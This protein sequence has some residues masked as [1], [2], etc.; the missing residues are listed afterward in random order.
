MDGSDVGTPKRRP[1]SQQGMHYTT[2][3]SP[4]RCSSA[5]ATKRPVTTSTKVI[6]GDLTMPLILNSSK[7]WLRPT[8]PFPEIYPHLET[9][10]L[11]P[12]GNAAKNT[13]A[14]VEALETTEKKPECID[15][16]YQGLNSH[17]GDALAAFLE[18]KQPHNNPH[19]VQV[20]IMNSNPKVGWKGV[21]PICKA[22]AFDPS[23]HTL[24]CEHVD[25]GDEG[26]LA[27]AQV[28]QSNTTLTYVNIAANNITPEGVQ[29]L[30]V[31]LT[32]NAT[33]QFLGL[34]Y[35]KIKDQ[36]GCAMAKVTS[37][38]PLAS[39]EMM[40]C[41]MSDQTIVA[42][43]LSLAANTTLTSLKMNK[44]E[45]SEQAI[46][47]LADLLHKNTTLLSVSISGPESALTK[48]RA[49]CRRNKRLKEEEGTK[50][51]EKEVIRLH[52]QSRK[53]S[54][55]RNTLKDYQQKSVDLEDSAAKT[56][57]KF[58]AQ[59]QDIHK[60]CR[61][62][63]ATINYSEQVVS[64]LLQKR[65][66]YKAS[67]EKER[68]SVQETMDT[69]N[70]TL[71]DDI[72]KTKRA[73]QRLQEEQE[74]LSKLEGGRETRQQDLLAQI[75][76]TIEETKRYHQERKETAKKVKEIHAKLEDLQED[77]RAKNA[78]MEAQAAEKKAA[79]AAKAKNKA[80]KAAEKKAAAA[81]MA[82]LLGDGD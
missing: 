75:Q 43:G 46:E 80:K 34:S 70:D 52:H 56:E 32:H 45:G 47:S 61:E 82:S 10:R 53:L 11:E 36:G 16:F 63:M 49:V 2:L 22:L 74:Q 71:Q 67:A 66:E 39:L 79:A 28:L 23:V 62:V 69:L 58:Q 44:N 60:K 38:C 4:P 21:I 37:L 77:L 30:T 78:I 26:A 33:L 9:F 18:N 3:P 19:R 64:D 54:L 51:L 17:I 76:A 68:I 35:N 31:A 7:Q 81:A 25:M 12:F 1:V 55:A 40:G 13:A 57:T 24:H 59:K 8:N 48:L 6:H 20:L 50:I 72:I 5:L 42:L 73:E 15:L 65:Q 14:H 27:L 41:R 29:P